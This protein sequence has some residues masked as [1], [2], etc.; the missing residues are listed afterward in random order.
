MSKINGTHGKYGN[1]LSATIMRE[2][3]RVGQGG[4]S[5]GRKRE[6]QNTQPR[7][8]SKRRSRNKFLK[9]FHTMDLLIMKINSTTLEV[10]D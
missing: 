6:K 7:R 9:L 3:E 1:I 10:K 8:K 5:G 4:K 2:R